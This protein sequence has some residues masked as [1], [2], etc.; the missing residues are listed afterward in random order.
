MIKG[1]YQASYTRFLAITSFFVQLRVQPHQTAVLSRQ[2]PANPPA[3]PVPAQ[4][5][6]L[7]Q[8]HAEV[9]RSLCK[10]RVVPDEQKRH[11]H[12]WL[13]G[14]C[15]QL[16][17]IVC[18]GKLIG[19]KGRLEPVQKLRQLVDC[20]NQHPN[21][22]VA[23]DHTPT[24]GVIVPV[25]ALSPVRPATG[26]GHDISIIDTTGEQCETVALTL[27]KRFAN[28]VRTKIL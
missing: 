22:L 28:P 13:L 24:S 21:V 5:A 16:L 14:P 7:L 23:D 20:I 10:S 26:H 4:V 3:A 1:H 18:Q 9:A 15:T 12:P 8:H 6:Q 19:A 27:L 11:A 25:E 17:N 2:P